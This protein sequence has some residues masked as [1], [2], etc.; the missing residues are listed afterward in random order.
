MKRKNILLAGILVLLSSIVLVVYGYAWYAGKKFESLEG[1]VNP[2]YF[3]G[4]NGSK[5][6]PFKITNKIHMYNLAWLQY[7]GVFNKDVLDDGQLKQYHFKISVEEIDMTGLALPPIGTE[8]NPFIGSF[9]GNGCVIKNVIT[10]NNISSLKEHP[11]FDNFNL[12]SV[13]GFFGVIGDN[14]TLP[15]TISN[16]VNS[17]NNFFLDNVMVESNTDT[18][19]IGIVAGYVNANIQNIGVTYSKISLAKGMTHLNNMKKISNYSLIGY[20]DES[21]I[22]WTDKPGS[23][24][25]GY[26]TS[27]D[28]SELDDRMLSLFGTSGLEAKE[29]LPFQGTGEAVTS[30]GTTVG[31]KAADNNIGY[32]IGGDLKIYSEPKKNIDLTSF[33]Y[34]AGASKSIFSLPYQDYDRYYEAPD[35]NIIDATFNSPESDIYMLRLQ[36][37]LDTHNDLVTIE[38]GALWG[39]NFEKIIVPRRCIWFVPQKT[40]ILK[41]IIVNPNNGVNFTLS[42]FTR[43][44]KITHPDGLVTGDY[45]SSMSDPHPII[46][47]NDFAGLTYGSGEVRLNNQPYNFENK[48]GLAYYFTVEITQEMI[49][50]CYEFALSRDAGTD[51]AYFW[52][53]D[54]GAAGGGIVPEYIG[55]IKDVDFVYNITLNISENLSEVLF[56]ID[57]TS[58]TSVIFYFRRNKL[59]GVLYFIV[60]AE[61][62]L[63]FDS[64]GNGKKQ[65]ADTKECQ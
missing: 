35:Q 22:E 38:N 42:Y 45:S 27:T 53:L 65:E 2:S 62:G 33:Y 47:A 64:I 51:G 17:V 56:S 52:Y 57:G 61:N 34:P 59:N 36:S 30:G 15:H 29:Y 60:P 4:G 10:S 7:L 39:K 6:Q 16:T 54:I 46:D 19:L 20:V 37:K 5:E 41:F 50:D 58:I 55:M 28:L 49:D 3:A 25:P 24:G 8:D 43:A 9:E 11:N 1:K 63:S 14:G 31:E 23:G 44:A 48:I 40:G 32:Y 13:V 21:N 26:G 18:T 12:G